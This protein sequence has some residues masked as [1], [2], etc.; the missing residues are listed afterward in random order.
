MPSVPKSRVL[1]RALYSP[2]ITTG[3]EFGDQRLIEALRRHRGQ[4][5]QAM[6]A[7]VVDEVQR[8]SPQEQYDDITM[9]VARCRSG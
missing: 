6:V 7:S 9:I 2:E 4:P 1:V 8:F 5:S 3:E